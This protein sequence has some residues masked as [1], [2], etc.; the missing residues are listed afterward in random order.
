[1]EQWTVRL[2]NQIYKFIIITFQLFSLYQVP[3]TL[4]GLAVWN[5]KFVWQVY[6]WQAVGIEP[7][8]FPLGHMLPSTS[9]AISSSAGQSW[10]LVRAGAYVNDLGWPRSQVSWTHIEDVA[11]DVDG[12]M[13][14]FSTHYCWVHRGSVEWEV[15]PTLLHVTSSGNWTLDLLIL[16]PTPY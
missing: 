10:V 2:Q 8:T 7:L 1:M 13:W 11:G 15:C 3:I 9:P 4:G 6:T 16:S 5:E 12:G 14:L